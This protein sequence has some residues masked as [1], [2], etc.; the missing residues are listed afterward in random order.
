MAEDVE[1]GTSAISFWAACFNNDQDANL[2]VDY[3]TNHGATWAELGDFTVTRGALQLIILDIPTTGSTRFRIVQTSGMRVNIDDIT[4]F[5]RPQ[6]LL[7]DVNNDGE[8]NIS[9][10]NAVIDII[11]GGTA[12]DEIMNYA[13]VSSDHEINISDI[14]AILDLIMAD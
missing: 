11:L 6:H 10:V 3:S 12:D 9:D 8:V 14:N 4:I 1:G 13:D 2:R 7:G 5:G